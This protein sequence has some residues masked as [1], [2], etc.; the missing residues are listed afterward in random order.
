MLLYILS[1]LKLS[2]IHSFTTDVSTILKLVLRLPE[3]HINEIIQSACF[4]V[5][6]LSMGISSLRLQNSII[7]FNK[8]CLLLRHNCSGK[9]STKL[10]TKANAQLHLGFSSWHVPHYRTVLLPFLSSLFFSW[11]YNHHKST[12]LKLLV[13]HL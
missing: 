10:M 6:L 11:D 5:C 12:K 13:D 8:K 2:T 4:C 9:M 1:Q 7:L 3:I